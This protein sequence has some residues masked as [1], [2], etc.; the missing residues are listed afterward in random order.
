LTWGLEDTLPPEFG[1]APPWLGLE[2]LP[3]GALGNALGDAFPAGPNWFVDASRLTVRA[4]AF[5]TDD[6]ALMQRPPTEALCSPATAR[7]STA[8][9]CWRVT[10]KMRATWRRL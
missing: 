8:P 5:G 4:T 10:C 2:D 3:G 6:C 9:S 7:R 1:W